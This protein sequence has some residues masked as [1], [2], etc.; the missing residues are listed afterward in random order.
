MKDKKETKQNNSGIIVVMIIVAIF[1]FGAVFLS[2]T[3]N[4]SNVGV[5]DSQTPDNQNVS[6]TVETNRFTMA[7]N[8]TCKITE[9]SDKSDTRTSFRLE[10]L[11]TNNPY[12]VTTTQGEIGSFPLEKR[13]EN[14]ETVGLQFV[15]PA[16]GSIDTIALFK[17]TGYFERSESTRIGTFESSGQCE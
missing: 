11:Y 16:T 15:A 7:N 5:S 17:K 6:D 12:L 9:N 10:N 3:F 1:I 2:N 14:Q 4:N 13:V 8:L